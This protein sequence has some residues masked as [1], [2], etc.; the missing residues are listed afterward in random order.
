MQQ[1]DH[2]NSKEIKARGEHSST[3]GD[4]DM[5][6]LAPEVRP[7]SELQGQEST[8]PPFSPTKAINDP[9]NGTVVG[10]LSSTGDQD[11]ENNA[12]NSGTSSELDTSR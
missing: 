7:S 11:R 5:P 1:V 9:G 8:S 2:V 10:T 3:K 4:E 6:K 12:N